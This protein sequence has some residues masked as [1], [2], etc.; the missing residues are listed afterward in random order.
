MI[1]FLS[2]KIIS[3][4]PPLILLDVNGVGY[5]IFSP[6]FTFYRLPPVGQTINLHIHMVVRED[7]MQLYG[8]FEEKERALF[9]ELIKVSNIGPKL[10]LAILSGIEADN[11]VQCVHQQDANSLVRIPGVGKKTA[12]RLILEMQGRLE[13]WKTLFYVNDALPQTE[14]QAFVSEAISALIALGYKSREAEMAIK[15]IYAEG[16]SSQ[17][18]IRMA[19]K[20]MV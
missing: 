10:A 2:G 12:E 5:E 6:M 16:L 13:D 20:A 17:D 14:S 19:L 9:R 11:F 15:R 18:L 4:K 1:G 8:F 7:A 3:S